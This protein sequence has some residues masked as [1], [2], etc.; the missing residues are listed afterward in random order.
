M[1]LCKMKIKRAIQDELTLLMKE[2]PV[3]TLTG[4]RQSGKTTLAKMTFPEYNYCNLENPEIRNLA[5]KDTKALFTAFPTPVI[6]DEVQRVP[7]LLSYIQTIVDKS[8]ENGLFLLTG[9][10][11][12]S[13]DQEVSQSL[14]GRTALLQLL[15]FS[16]FELKQLNLNLSRDEQIYRGFLPRIYDKQQEPSKAYRNY[17]QTYIERDLRQLI[18]IKD[19]GSFEDFIKL[20]AGRVGQLLNLNSLAN[21]LGISSTTLAQWLSVLEASFIILRLRPY[22]ENFGKRIIKSPKIYFT[23]VGLVAYLLGIEKPVQVSRDPL[24]GGL[25]ENMVVLEAVKARLNKGVD[26]NLFFFRDNNGNEIDL[27]YKK[28]N[29]LVPIEIKAAMTFN[30]KLLKGIGYFRKISK[31]AS[32]G[33]LIYAG[34]MN[35]K[36]D[37]YEVM[38]YSDTYR[39]FS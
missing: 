21:D 34:N 3:V 4:P 14:A 7:E 16:I 30:N 32:G 20:L 36:G 28:H 39:I 1:Y 15:P 33:Y 11:Q 6:I 24:L 5:K 31:K 37:N 23:D 12:L 10:N 29:K 25:F 2:Y 18:K 8:D 13:L 38:H 9:S 19:L 22:Y 17:F 35:T 26:P 27:I